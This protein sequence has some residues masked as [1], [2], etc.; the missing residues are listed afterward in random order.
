MRLR[1]LFM[2]LAVCLVLTMLPLSALALSETIVTSAEELRSALGA[3]G[4]GDIVRLGADMKN[5]MTKLA[6][7]RDVI[8][9]LNGYRLEITVNSDGTFTGVN[10]IELG[11]DVTLTIRDTSASSSGKLIVKNTF[12]GSSN[13][14]RNTGAAIRVTNGT[15][16]IESGTVTATGGHNGAGI[17]GGA[18]DDSGTVIINGG[19]VT[20][21]GGYGSAGI[22]AGNYGGCDA[23]IINGGTVTATGG[24]YGP[25]IGSSSAGGTISISGGTVKAEGGGTGAGIGGGRTS[26][27][28]STLIISGGSVN[29]N[30]VAG[31]NA[32]SV[33]DSVGNPLELVT[34]TL[35]GDTSLKNA[36]LDET[37]HSI[38]TA[39]GSYAYGTNDIKTDNLGKVYFYLPAH[40][41][42]VSLRAGGKLY[43]NQSV[44]VTESGTNTAVLNIERI[45]ESITPP[46]AITGIANGTGKTAQALGLP[47]HVTLVTYVGSVSGSVAWDVD[48]CTYDPA[49]T[50]EQTFTVNGTVTL[51]S[52]VFNP[53]GVSLNVSVSVTVNAKAK[54]LMS[55]TS[56]APITGVVNGAGKTAQALGL[57]AHVTLVTDMDNVSGSVTW[58]VAS[59]AYDPASMQEQTFTVNGTVTLPNDVI[60]PSSVSLDVSVSVTVNAKIYTLVSIT[61][62]APITGVANGTDKT[63]E[64]L[65]LPAHVTLVT[66]DGNI[67]GSVAWDVISCAYDP[68]AVEEQTFTVNGTVPLPNGVI[69][70][71]G[72]SLNVSVSVTVNAAAAPSAPSSAGPVYSTR[73]LTDTPSGLSVAGA[74]SRNATLRVNSFTPARNTTDPALAAIVTRMDSLE[75]T[76]IFCADITVLGN[77]SGPLTLSFTVGEQ[78]DGQTVT[79][80]HAKNGKLST[81]IAVV[82]NGIATFAVDSLSPFALFAPVTEMDAIGIPK[83]GDSGMLCGMLAAGVAMLIAGIAAVQ[84]RRRYQKE[85]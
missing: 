63:A 42:S 37:G 55:I 39:G 14:Y 60:N 9:D 34:F 54:T 10:G 61:P 41:Y 72:V 24:N 77:Y 18:D 27:T 50:Q 76:L 81:Y 30:N 11:E 29:A 74:L 79:L 5:I 47:S 49:S 40:T 51:P 52:D 66:D 85:S 28:G 65:G 15:L 45:L 21:S 25:G 59:C 3:S 78:Y 68:A 69:N 44:T 16:V 38:M 22:G 23:V 17:G 20:A 33:V 35:M 2:F 67:N 82:N 26:N 84:N 13:Y 57:P 8:L 58:D 70:P 64:A 83:T 46:A 36:A 80:L 4:T 12:L 31:A 1:K 53:N 7:D 32:A 19:T 71:S 73:T 56:P 62:P 48:S 43:T 6:V 75:D